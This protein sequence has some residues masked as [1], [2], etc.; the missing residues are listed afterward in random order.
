MLKT[1]IRDPVTY[2]RAILNSLR[3]SPETPKPG[4]PI[5]SRVQNVI[6]GDNALAVQAASD[7][8]AKEGFHAES[9][10]SDWQGEAREVGSGSGSKTARNHY[11][12]STPFA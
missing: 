4:D 8:A 5:F 2:L 7:Q 1:S 11:A 12:A 9:L 10:G 3:S 6:V